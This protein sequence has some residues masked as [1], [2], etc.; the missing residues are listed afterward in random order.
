MKR[1]RTLILG[2]AGRDFHNFNVVYRA[3]RAHEVVA[4]TAEQIPH[5]ADRRYPPELAGPLYPNGIPVHPESELE[6]L[7]DSAAIDL[8]VLAYSDLSHDSV[9]HLAS[10]VNAAGADF[11][12][13]GVRRTMLRSQLPV[14]SVCASRTG[15]GKS[16][17]SR[18]VV[19][20]LRSA[21]LK[22]AVLRHPMPYGDLARQRVQ[23]FADRTDLERQRVTIEEREEYEPHLAMQSIVWA[24]V[25]YAAILREAEREAHVIVWDGGNNDTSFLQSDVYITVVDPHRP[26]H[27]LTYYPGETNVRLADVVIINKVDTAAPADVQRVRLNVTSANPSAEILEAESQI[28]VMD[29]AVLRDRLVL[30][31]EDGPTLTH[32]GMGF[33]VAVIGARRSGATL[34]DP[35][36]FAVGELA[37]TLR[38]YPHIDAA[39]PAMGYG[40]QQLRDLEA[41]IAAAAQ[42]GATALAIGTPID[43]AQLVDIAIPHTRVR[44]SL[45]LRDVTALERILAAVTDRARRAAGYDQP[46]PE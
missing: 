6:R 26:G 46:P 41:T 29:P 31:V 43:L 1:M 18:E 40:A 9:G 37:D 28:E 27:E 36:Q 12:L 44:Y 14:V 4:F 23:R 10:R 8:C 30:A 20:V 15:A 38:K 2:A 13:L 19:R 45:R 5:I 22:V 3:D 34:L 7:I 33:G 17:T 39:L 32:G 42:A 11:A 24:G 25:D 21:G 35:R 16:Q